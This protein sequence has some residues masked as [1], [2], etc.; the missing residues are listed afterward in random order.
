VRATVVGL[1]ES[2]ATRDKALAA[3]RRFGA[4]GA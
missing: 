2:R 1:V 4:R 3:M